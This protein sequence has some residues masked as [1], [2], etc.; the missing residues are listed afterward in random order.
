MRE[1]EERNRRATLTVVCS[2]TF[3][4]TL[5][6]AII[7]LAQ[8]ILAEEFES[9]VADVLW[10]SLS[11]LVVAVGLALPMGRLGDLYGRKRVFATGWTV[12][13][14]GLAVAAIAPTLGFLVVAR[15]VQ[16]CGAAMIGANGPAII[17][18]TTPGH[19]R[20]KALGILAATVGAGQA[21]GPVLGGIL[22]SSL[23]WRAVFW[24]R[25]PLA[26]IVLSAIRRYLPDS[27]R[28]A[29][30]PRLDFTGSVLIVATTGTLVLAINRATA[31][32]LTSGAT[33]VL[34]ASSICTAVAF[35][36]IERR[37]S[38]PVV[39]LTLFRSRGFSLAIL[40]SVFH[41]M[42]RAGV[43]VLIPFFLIE[44]R[45]HSLLETSTFMVAIPLTLVVTAPLSGSLADR[46]GPRAPTTV[47]QAILIV[48]LLLLATVSVDTPVAGI[49]FILV[50]VGCGAGLFGAPNTSAIMNNAP[51]RNLGTASA[52]SATSRRI[53]QAIGVAVAGAL[54]AARANVSDS[55]GEGTITAIA[56]DGA[57]AGLHLAMLTGAAIV[58]VA[59]LV[60]W[61]RPGR[62]GPQ[63]VGGATAAG[64]L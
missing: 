6:A 35:V 39:D 7:N 40:T 63:P 44:A 27:G 16:A 47:A 14:I 59:M 9:T 42:G 52:S 20:G 49:I 32:S 46:Y 55:S 54:F 4:S 3:I 19:H 12:Y 36:H 15:T 23:G 25:I 24:A 22:M 31:W 64:Q 34:F 61:A 60:S 10:V 45:G 11:F 38:S 28:P 41:H 51:S 17:T 58:G 21:T 33:L 26:V 29:S 13:T 8:P 43:V 2:G 62:G 1:L 5:D 18:A 53:G 37:S 48:A 50:L 30:R 56:P 57:T